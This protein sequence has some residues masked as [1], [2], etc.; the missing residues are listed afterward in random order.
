M[1]SEKAVEP[2]INALTTDKESKVRKSA[3]KALGEMGSER[4]V[5]PLINVFTT[6]KE[7]DVRWSIAEALEK[8]S[9]KTGKRIVLKDKKMNLKL[10][11]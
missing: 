8:I 11:I 7:S 3:A 6:A 4:A 5:E 10:K 9:K 1:G 2:L